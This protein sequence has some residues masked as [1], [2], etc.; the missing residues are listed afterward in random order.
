MNLLKL[1][2]TSLNNVTSHNQNSIRVILDE[3]NNLINSTTG[4][5]FNYKEYKDKLIDLYNNL[6]GLMTR[7]LHINI[8][9]TN[10]YPQKLTGGGINDKIRFTYK[11]KRRTKRARR[12]KPTRRKTNKEHKKVYYY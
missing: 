8:P 12:S 6:R 9:T 4:N 3:I 11:N 2:Q 10:E 5:R 1:L 7:D